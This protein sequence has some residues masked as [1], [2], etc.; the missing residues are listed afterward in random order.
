MGGD[1]HTAERLFEQSDVVSQGERFT[2]SEEGV[3]E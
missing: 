3:I 2:K 1:E